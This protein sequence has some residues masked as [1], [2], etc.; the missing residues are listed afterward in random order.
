MRKVKSYRLAAFTLIEIMVVLLVI[1]LIATLVF[2][3]FGN[4]ELSRLKVQ[5]RRIQSA[6]YL[7]YNLSVMEKANYRLVFDLDKQCWYAEK[8]SGIEYVPASNELLLEHCLPDSVWIEELEVQDRELF[9]TGKE[10]IHFSPFGYSEPARIYITN[11][12]ND[13]GSG[14]TLFTEPMTGGV[15]VYE[16]RVQ[17]KDLE[18]LK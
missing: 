13:P 14:Y 16:G 5:A 15:R 2:P 18:N 10:Y 1:G 3:S 12:S 4:F 8:K 9:K 6:V 11:E 17:Y 7:T